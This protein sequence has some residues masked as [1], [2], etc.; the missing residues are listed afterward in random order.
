M[1][2]WTFLEPGYAKAIGEEGEEEEGKRVF[3]SGY[4]GGTSRSVVVRSD[5]C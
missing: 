3:G 5:P 1:E 4:P 2:A